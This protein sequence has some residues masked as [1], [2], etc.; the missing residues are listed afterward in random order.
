MKKKVVLNYDHNGLI[1]YGYATVEKFGRGAY[2]VKMTDEIRLD[3]ESDN[4]EEFL[5]H[6]IVVG[7][8]VRGKGAKKFKD[9]ILYVVSEYEKHFGELVRV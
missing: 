6:V 8:A 9:E 3:N 4:I 2:T 7:S 5:V 1:V